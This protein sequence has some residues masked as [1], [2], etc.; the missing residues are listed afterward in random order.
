MNKK[1]A[2]EIAFAADPDRPYEQP[3]RWAVDEAE[4]LLDLD[5]SKWKEGEPGPWHHIAAVA[6]ALV[7]EENAP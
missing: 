6:L 7:E 3:P 5:P 1:R 2:R 4:A